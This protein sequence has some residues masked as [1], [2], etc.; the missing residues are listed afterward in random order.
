MKQTLHLIIYI[1]TAAILLTGC[2]SKQQTTDKPIVSVTI[3][4]FHYFVDQIAQGLVDVNVM[5]PAGN[6]PETYEPTPQQMVDLAQSCL[7]LKV[8]H[9]GFE[10]TWMDKIAENAPHLKTIDTSKG[11]VSAK[12]AAGIEDPHTWMSISSARTIAQNIHK[13]LCTQMPEHK[14]ELTRNFQTFLI[15]LD[16]QKH[17]F[18]SIMTDRQRSFVIYHPAL[19]YLARDYG[20]EQLP[21]EEEGREPSA[22]QLQGLIIRAKQEKIQTVFIQREFANRNIQTFLNATH[23]TPTEINPLSYDWDKQMTLI[24]Q[25]LTR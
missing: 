5:V 7:Y 23:A 4:P 21:I 18:D 22:Q 9:I 15:R 1:C 13:A 25:K 14:A 8:G 16:K 20:I 19:T 17:Q 24:I 2:N 11:I 3:E 10:E 6:N 12:T